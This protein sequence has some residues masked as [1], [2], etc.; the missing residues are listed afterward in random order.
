MKRLFLLTLLW[1]LPL[2]ARGTGGALAPLEILTQPSAAP[3]HFIYL[4]SYDDGQSTPTENHTWAAVVEARDNG[5]VETHG[6]DWLP[7]SGRIVTLAMGPERARNF[8]LKTAFDRG[9]ASHHPFSQWGPYQTTDEFY[10]LALKHIQLLESRSV[11]YRVMDSQNRIFKVLDPNS[12]P[13]PRAMMCIHAVSDLVYPV[14]KRGFLLTGNAVGNDATARLAS[15]FLPWYVPNAVVEPDLEKKMDAALGLTGY[16][17]EH[18]K[19][20]PKKNLYCDT[21]E[22]CR[23]IADTMTL[24][25]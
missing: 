15:H 6:I 11:W 25:E 8:P 14:D 12:V 13:T 23:D 10:A 4:F 24:P 2:T 19:L 16:T 5:E 3:R 7:I 17:I 20:E 22:K 9:L 21:L 1:A 18:R